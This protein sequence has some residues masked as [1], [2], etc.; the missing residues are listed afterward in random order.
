M[1]LVL[2]EKKSISEI[3]RDA[4]C[5]RDDVVVAE[6]GGCVFSKEEADFFC[7]PFLEKLVK[8]ALP[9]G[10]DGYVL[11]EDTIRDNVER[12]KDMLLDGDFGVVVNAM[13]MDEDGDALFDY[14][15]SLVGFG[16]RKIARLE[17]CDIDREHIRRQYALAVGEVD[18]Y[19]RGQREK[20]AQVKR[21]L[22]SLVKEKKIGQ[23]V[24]DYVTLLV[25][26]EEG[27]R[28]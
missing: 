10:K 1:V 7:V 19:A 12:I 15:S 21:I 27:S 24:Y 6:I 13:P 2:T 9:G 18:E 25:E 22:Y 17:L 3:V 4:L 26:H 20:V 11:G 23:D 28:S 14:A 5:D 16:N 8:I